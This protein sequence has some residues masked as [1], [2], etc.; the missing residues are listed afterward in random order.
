MK[1][2]CFVVFLFVMIFFSSQAQAIVNVEDA[3]IDPD[4][5]G[6][7]TALNISVSGANSN[8]VKSNSRVTLLTHWQHNIHTDFL[9]LKHRFGRINGVTNTNSAFVHYRHRTQLNPDWAAEV[10]TQ[11]SRDLFARMSRRLLLGSGVRWTILEKVNKSSVYMGLGAFHE[12]ETLSKKAGT[13]DQVD[14]SLWR[15]NI[16]L[17]L[18]YQ[19]NDHVRLTNTLYYQ[20]SFKS[21][22][23][24]RLLEQATAVVNLHE[25]I[26]LT[27][28]ID[29]IKD[30]MPPQTVKKDNFYYLTGI[31]IRF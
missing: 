18:K 6:V 27:V 3:I 29:F 7:N 25:N 30:S 23:D 1:G 12:R 11:L 20:P 15:S 5:D 31:S 14:T 26:D 28:S 8:T 16:Y 19:L 24:H 2:A 17:V 22:A 9:S 21:S 13:T 10:F 4:K